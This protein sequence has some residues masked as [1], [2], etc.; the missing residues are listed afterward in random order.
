VLRDA[1]RQIERG[2]FRRSLLSPSLGRYAGLDSGSP[3]R[4]SISRDNVGLVV[5]Y[6]LS[7]AYAPRIVSNWA[8]G[9]ET[10]V[11]PQIS[12]TFLRKLSEKAN[13]SF[14]LIAHRIRGPKKA[15]QPARISLL[16]TVGLLE[17][18]SHQVGPPSR[19]CGLQGGLS[20]SSFVRL[21]GLATFLFLLFSLS[22]SSRYTGYLFI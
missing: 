11:I 18:P 21:Q 10:M 2:N 3:R 13:K 5:S 7:T 17:D 1:A 15:L 9:H 22:S 6:F 4:S 20:S 12:P 19:A 14:R 8:R 16:S